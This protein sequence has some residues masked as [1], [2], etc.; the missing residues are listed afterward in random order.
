MCLGSQFDKLRRDVAKN[1]FAVQNEKT[2]KMSPTKDNCKTI[3]E[4]IDEE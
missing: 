3:L 4:M 1:Q 2:K